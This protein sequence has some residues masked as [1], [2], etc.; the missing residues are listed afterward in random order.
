MRPSALLLAVVMVASGM[1]AGCDEGNGG[2]ATIS[3]DPATMTATAEAT[4]T[5]TAPG[6]GPSATPTPTLMPTATP[7]AT[8][9]DG[10]VTLVVDGAGGTA[11]V[12]VELAQTSEE[13]TTGLM[14][15]EFLP[16]GEGMLFIFEQPSNT[17]F[18]MR[19]TLI[20]LDIAYLA[21]DGRIREIRQG[22]PLNETVLRPELP[23]SY[24]LEVN[25]GWFASRGMGIGD[26]VLIPDRARQKG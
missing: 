2:V 13:I 15:R 23:Y 8:P 3:P 7:T 6:A 21:E 16:E 11:E 18:W 22:E 26:R 20:P 19:N 12:R 4:S 1:L 9:N 10:R 25:A 5:A 14:H 24:V 17:G